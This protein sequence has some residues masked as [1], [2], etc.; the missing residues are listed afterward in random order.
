MRKLRGLRTPP[1]SL[2]GWL[3]WDIASRVLHSFEDV[4]SV[5]EVGAGVGGVAVRLA[6]EYDYVGLEPDPSSYVVAARRVERGAGGTLFQSDDLALVASRRFDLVVAFEVLEH[7][8][9]DCAAVARWAH[10][11]RPGGHVLVSVPAWRHRFGSADVLVGHYRRYDRADVVDL[12]TR[13]GL[14]DVRVLAYGFPLGFALESIWNVVA[15]RKPKASKSEGTAASGRWFQPPEH[16]AP[17]TWAIS[18]PFRLL[19]RPFAGTALGTGWV[20]S[21]RVGG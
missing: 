14:E 7:I 20:A 1:L 3:R 6:R 21:G 16:L 10:L 12:L 19:Q 15:A 5:L 17:V 4:E 2:N 18:A 13:A 11:V 9:D 8:E